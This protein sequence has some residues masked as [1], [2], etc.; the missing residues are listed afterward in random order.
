VQLVIADAAARYPLAIDPLL[1]SAT[2]SGG[3][4]DAK[5][6]A[7]VAGAGDVNGD[8]FADVIVGAPGY[9]A[10]LAD[11]G[12]AF[13][14]LGSAAGITGST[15][16]QAHAR[17]ESDQAG[18]EMGASVAGAGDVNGD[19]YADVIVGAP[20]YDSGQTD[21]GAAFLFLGSPTGVAN[22]NPTTAAA[23]IES[24]QPGAKLGV[25]AGAKDVNGDG[26]A[27]L[28]AGALYQDYSTGGSFGPSWTVLPT[29]LRLESKETSLSL[30]PARETSMPTATTT[31]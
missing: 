14:F 12:A 29:R 10:G 25:V 27:D 9:D 24:D 31:S 7:S 17:L 2:I 23:R 3:E 1:T 8:G 13:L 11:E 19:G 26:Y 30:S 5:F 21:E 28:I 16:A 18:A 20:L 4:A 6:G 15:A 22:G